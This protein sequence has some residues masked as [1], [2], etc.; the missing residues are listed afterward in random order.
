ML[1]SYK[2]FLK[3]AVISVMSTTLKLGTIQMQNAFNDCS[4]KCA[5]F[6]DHFFLKYG[7]YT[8]STKNLKYTHSSHF[9]KRY[10]PESTDYKT[11]F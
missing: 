11:P 5:C 6:G 2:I 3:T 4:S 7:N 9:T 10:R 8:S 1:L